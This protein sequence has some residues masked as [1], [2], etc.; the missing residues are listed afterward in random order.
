MTTGR[1]GRLVVLAAFLIPLAVAGCGV[2]H[3]TLS[4]VSVPSTSNA[5]VPA[6]A[7]PPPLRSFTVIGSGD[8]LLHDALWTQAQRD[9]AAEGR[10]GMDFAPLFAAVKPVVSGADLAICHLETPLADP[11]GPFS[12]YPI[13]NVPPQVT[14]A[15][16]DLG[17]DSCSTA[18]NHT[19]DQGVAG[20]TRTLNA[21]DAVG[22][23]HTGSARSALEAATPDLLR[24]R[25]VTVAQ[26]SYTF[27]FNGLQLPPDKPWL[28]NPI[29]VNT[30]LFDA[31]MA[32]L[33]G[34]EVVIVSMHWGTEYQ[35]EADSY[36]TTLAHK[37]L[38][39]PDI[40]L[41][42]GDHVHVVQPLQKIGDKWVVYGMGNEV[43]WQNQAQDTRD[44][45][46]PRFT[47][48]EVSRGV[49]KVTK[50]EVVPIHMWL[51]GYPARLYDVAA[52]LA[53]PATPAAI[54][55]S[56]AA[57]LRRTRS[58]LGELGAF[59]AGLVLVGGEFAGP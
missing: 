30:I 29:D 20:V 34:A 58:V 51:D 23:K 24:A 49:F 36:Q 5:P 56:C 26:L 39:S 33:A 11:S 46:I 48:T 8:V 16:A 4:P 28:A 47:F 9:A 44:G 22:I 15:L 45:I 14:V 54:R 2:A 42:L 37:L 53:S 27:S 19:L 3:P 41:I 13:F 10:T 50:A 12:N 25:G 32:H 17:Y 55:A 40:D 1:S 7:P 31:R 59:D 52:A 35:H 18:S 21:L 57:S 43:A 6:P 38:A